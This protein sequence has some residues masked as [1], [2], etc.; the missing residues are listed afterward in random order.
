MELL[1]QTQ[2]MQEYAKK[3]SRFCMYISW[4]EE[5]S[6]EELIKAAPYLK[7]YEDAILGDI[8]AFI[9][10][11]FDTEEEMDIYYDLTI[12][13]DGATKSNPYNGPVRVYTLTPSNE[14]ELWNENT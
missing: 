4:N 5:L 7:D 11:T 8:D 14:G 6:F 12:G 10:L 1:T 2:L 13:D 3:S 9:F